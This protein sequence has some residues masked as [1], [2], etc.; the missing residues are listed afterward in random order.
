[1]RIHLKVC[2]TMNPYTF[3]FFLSYSY[4]LGHPQ[5]ITENFEDIG[6]YFGII[7]CSISAPKGLLHPVLPYRSRGKLTFPL[8]RTCTDSQ[9][10]KCDHSDKERLLIGTWVSEEVKKAVAVGYKIVKVTYF[11]I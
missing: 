4:P 7:K 10:K 1:M 6:K 2:A 5:V 9:N 8:C 11:F 3:F